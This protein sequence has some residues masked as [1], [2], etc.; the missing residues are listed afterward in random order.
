MVFNGIATGYGRAPNPY[1]GMQRLTDDNP[2]LPLN[3]GP[4]QVPALSPGIRFGFA[5]DVFGNGK[6]AIRGGFGQNLRRCR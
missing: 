5:W 6:T 1:T 4:Y 3:R 2:L